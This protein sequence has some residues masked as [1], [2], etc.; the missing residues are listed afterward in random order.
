MPLRFVQGDTMYAYELHKIREA[1]LLRTAAD[2]R[3]VRQLRRAA[4]KAPE[5]QAGPPGRRP[6][7][8]P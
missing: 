5:G 8:T 7:R 1:E 6:R 2:R 3:L 4:G